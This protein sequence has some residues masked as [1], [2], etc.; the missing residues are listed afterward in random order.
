MPKVTIDVEGKF[1]DNITGGALKAIAS[2]RMLELMARKVSG[3][4]SVEFKTG[5]FVSSVKKTESYAR[6]N[7]IQRL[8]GR[9]TPSTAISGNTLEAGG[10][11]ASYPTFPGWGKFNSGDKSLPWDT[12]IGRSLQ[13]WGDRARQGLLSANAGDAG[14]SLGS[15][16]LRG[17]EN[18]IKT[19]FSKINPSVLPFIPSPR[20]ESPA[21]SVGT[22][23]QWNIPDSTG[24]G[25]KLKPVID[26]KPQ[27]KN[28]DLSDR[29]RQK[30]KSGQTF[31][32]NA[33]VRTNWEYEQ[34]DES[35]I[36]PERQYGFSSDAQLKTRW[37]Y[38]PFDGS[39]LT[40]EE[41]YMF[42]TDANV[43]AGWKYNPFDGSLLTPESGYSFATDANVE[44]GWKYNPFD[45][46]LLTPE[47][48]YSFATDANVEA[49]WKYNPFDGSLLT[50]EGGYSFATDAN[51]EAGWTFNPFDDSLL[52]PEGGYSFATD[53]NIE[54]GWTFN[55][56][57]GSLLTP[58]GGYSFATD[59]NVEAG[60]TFNPFDGSLLTPEGGYSFATDANVEAGWTFN[61]FDGSLLTPEG[62]YV[63]PVNAQVNVKW[64]FNRFDSTSIAPD[65]GYAFASGAVVDVGWEYERFNSEWIAPES[66]YSFSTSVNVTPNY[67]VTSKFT[68]SKSMFGIPDSVSYSQTVYV[69]P[70]IV[71]NK[72]N[73]YV[74]TSTLRRA[75]GGIIGP[76]GPIGFAEGGIVRGG[77]QIV[78]VA[79][80]GTP[81]MIIPL[82]S[83][84]RERGMQLWR[85]AGHMLGVEGFADGGIAGRLGRMA[86][87]PVFQ[88]R[89]INFPVQQEFQSLKTCT[90][91][92]E[93]EPLPRQ[94]S[95]SGSSSAANVSVD[96][97]GINITFQIDAGGD[98][99]SSIESNADMIADI[100]AGRLR[101]AVTDVFINSPLRGGE[102]V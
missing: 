24:S 25:M 94:H 19:G 61:P 101:R 67:S 44:A 74:P 16:L 78:T 14:K 65:A 20:A 76:N 4:S 31:D 100:I 5:P 15:E 38:N 35:W 95:V 9:A 6:D 68:P 2:L 97:S 28:T 99:V 11:A 13:E 62:G 43:K 88:P 17:Y 33:S 102:T 70:N 80:E 85:K 51:V 52:T 29:L 66:Y 21:K 22:L 36:S 93:P 3:I 37:K 54:A 7:G 72:A 47:G 91:Y 96:M 46:S 84:R 75:R 34:F 41:S 8:T 71:V 26:I 64:T 87:P 55:P 83:Q 63:F 58:E 69:T 23:K 59:A 73:G 32:V 77:P 92:T 18:T 53:A 30:F 39:L 50:P 90:N 82:G 79:E 98:V 49:G 81:E 89:T 56:F 10:M 86:E 45:G 60:W 48:G 42:A 27:I 40:P 12:V 57:D 1:T